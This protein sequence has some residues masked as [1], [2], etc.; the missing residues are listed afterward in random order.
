MEWSNWFAMSRPELL[1]ERIAC[2]QA[3]APGHALY[4]GLEVMPEDEI[5]HKYRFSAFIQGASDLPRRLRDG[6]FAYVLIV[7]TVTNVCCESSARRHD[8]EL[9][10][11]HGQR[12]QL[13][14]VGRRAHGDAG[15]F[16]CRVRG[17]DGHR[18]DHRLPAHERGAVSRGRRLST[19][20]H[21]IQGMHR[22]AL[23]GRV[24]TA[25]HVGMRVGREV[26]G[27]YPPLIREQP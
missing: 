10:D 16:L 5:V 26:S 9:Q 18:H 3:G 20:Q 19:W 25:L 22:K 24:G 13:R 11:R 6:G 27:R 17:C 4:A 21:L 23:S 8:V 14:P 12:R 1:Q 15:R 2:F 7:G